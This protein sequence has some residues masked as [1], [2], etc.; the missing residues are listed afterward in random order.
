MQVKE[1]RD[2][3]RRQRHGCSQCY[4]SPLQMSP[5]IGQELSQG[6]KAK[7]NTEPKELTPRTGKLPQPTLLLPTPLPESMETSGERPRRW[8]V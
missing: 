7:P 2:G 5:R 3:A 8:D 4:L 1:G 6:V